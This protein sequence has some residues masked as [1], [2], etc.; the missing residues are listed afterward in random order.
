MQSTD[1]SLPGARTAL[2]LLLLINLFN[3]LDR[4]VLAA[5]ETDIEA[6]Y[7]PEDEYPRDPQTNKRL[8]PTIEGKIG[9]LNT[10]FMVTYMLIAPL[11]GWLADRMKRWLLVAIGVILWSLASGATGLAATFAI[12]FLTRCL[13]GVGEAAYGPVAP[14]VIA[15]LYPVAKRGSKLAWFYAAIPVGSALGYIVGGQVAKLMGDWRWAFY[16]VVP[17]GIALGAW[18]LFMKEPKR[19]QADAGRQSGG[20][21]GDG[22]ATIGQTGRQADAEVVE[23]KAS[24]HDYLEILK[25]PSYLL[26]TFGM[27]AMTFAMGGLAFWMPR[28]VFEE[29]RWG[30]KATVNLIFGLIVVVA[31]LSATL[32]GGWVGDKLKPRY[33]GS[34]FLVSGLAMMLGFPLVL[35]VL[36]TPF[37]AAW[38][39]VFLAV[40]CLMFNTGPTN[41]IL[42]NVTHPSVRASA[43]ALNI[44][45]IHALGDAVSPM[46]IGFINGYTHNM[47]AGFLTVSFMFLAAGA[48]WLWGTLYLQHDTEWVEMGK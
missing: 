8:D 36:W 2:T 16:V 10:A 41:T 20:T 48:L 46:I 1:G 38:V 3:Y 25:T 39:F 22:A 30:D 12:I 37:P 4:Q 29:R 7:F 26:D 21:V 47:N 24:W 17:P 9:S 34:Y 44:F 31:G 28:Y 40:F 42:A 23:R 13:V 14:T 32:L 19:G 43:F 11:F 5:V 45:I 15:D 27:T 6:T 18:C 33:S 35:L